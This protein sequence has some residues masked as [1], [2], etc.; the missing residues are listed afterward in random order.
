MRLLL[1]TCLSGKTA[2]I[3]RSSGHDVVW[4]GAWPSDPGDA[5]ILARACNE[6]RILVTLDKDFGELA[7]VHGE[8]HC[9]IV[10]LVDCSV[11]RQAAT[12]EL[13]LA[14]HGELLATGGIVTAEPGRLRIRPAHEE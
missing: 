12:C 10:R 11:L 13:V 3:L 2:T 6:Q 5:A 9:G 7:V 8:P 14:R 1:D 4:A